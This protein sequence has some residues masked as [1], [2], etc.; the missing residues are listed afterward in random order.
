MSGV[1]VKS[2]KRTWAWLFAL[3]VMWGG[4]TAPI[5]QAAEGIIT[6]IIPE[7]KTVAESAGQ[8]FPVTAGLDGQE[9]QASFWSKWRFT[10]YLKNETAYRVREPRSITKIRNIAYL[11]AQYTFSKTVKFNYTGWAYHDLAYNLFDYRTIVA[12]SERNSLEPLVFVETLPQEK[13]SPVTE[14]RE[15][16]LDFFLKNIDIRIGKQYV[17]WGVLEGVRIT[18]EI[19]P[20]DFR[21]LILADLLD[22]RIPLWTVK[23]DH[24]RG[25]TTYEFIWIPDIQFHKPA[26]RGSEWELLQDIRDDQGNVLTKF[27]KSFAPENSEVGFKVNTTILDTEVALSYFYTWDDFP[28]IFRTA[29][30]D[31]T[32]NN[33][34]ILYPTYTRMSM[35]GATVVKQ[36]GPVIVKTEAAYVTDKYFGLKN[37]VD[38]DGD[39]FTDSNGELQRDHIR[40]GIGL[41]F[42]IFGMD[43]SPGYTQW[44]I[45]DYEDGFIQPQNDSSFSFFGRKEFPQ[46]SAIFQVLWIYLIKM[47]ESLLKPKLTFQASDKLQVSG[48]LDLFYGKSGFLGN[49][50]DGTANLIA[51]AQQRPQFLG[52][53]H[54]NDRIYMEFKYSF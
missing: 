46:N 4:G 48:G 1:D 17:V 39:G 32:P 20:I 31:Q 37:T 53:F 16:Y 40:W 49:V 34:P 52:N 25:D 43:M 54:D 12:R 45:I 24:Y 23:L 44:N 22:Y 6:D 47:D 2:T 13:D 26:P 7:E 35:Y 41:D 29:R 14:T 18:D 33:P 11:N 50:G 19:N 28:V 27:P 9:G 42:N 38:R 36:V 15:M 10:G 8:D 21:E 3:G 30:V 51:A 5:V